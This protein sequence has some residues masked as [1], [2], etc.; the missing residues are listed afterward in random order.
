MSG[1]RVNFERPSPPSE[2]R[3]R[4]SRDSGVG[5]SSSTEQANSG[6]KSDRRFTDQDREDQRYNVHALQEALDAAN[7]NLRDQKKKNLTIDEALS[8][9]HKIIREKEI[10]IR[11]L[12]EQNDNMKHEIVAARNQIDEHKDAFNDMRIERDE[13]RQRC[14]SLE[15]PVDSTAMMS[16]GSGHS[17][18]G[19]KRSKS[20]RDSKD[21]T[22]RLKTRINKP[23]KGEE[24]SSPKL[25]RSSSR[26][27]RSL[28]IDPSTS[29]RRPYIEEPED[30]SRPP[31]SGGSRHYPNYTAAS[32]VSPTIA[33]MEAVA[34]SNVPRTSYPAVPPIYQTAGYQQQQQQGGDY[35]PLPLP[36]HRGRRNH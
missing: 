2:S 29:S 1:K 19:I 35:V 27:R 32:L 8:N 14:L 20:K 34:M 15:E 30:R 9:S 21:Q 25:A 31:I 12:I 5:S 24:P 11:N 28:S 6:G 7:K 4:R 33:R 3:S 26:R 17:S 10:M 16:G 23:S 18:E 22:D 13:W 36:E